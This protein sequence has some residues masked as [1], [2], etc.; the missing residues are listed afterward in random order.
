MAG[1]DA[2][3]DAPEAAEKETDFNG[4]QAEVELLNDPEWIAKALAE[5]DDNVASVT[6]ELKSSYQKLAA[7]LLKIDNE[8]KEA[9][10]AGDE[11][12]YQASLIKKNMVLER[13]R[14]LEALDL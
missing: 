12:L 14:E 9:F 1:N 4:D 11:M 7:G 10:E 2:N 13:L 5:L 3:D 6:D 8:I